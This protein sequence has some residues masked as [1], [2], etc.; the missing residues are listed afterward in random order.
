MCS[1]RAGRGA[2]VGR[3]CV[4]SVLG[5]GRRK[6]LE[7]RRSPY[8]PEGFFCKRCSDVAAAKFVF[9]RKCRLFQEGLMRPGVQCPKCLTA[10]VEAEE[11]PEKVAD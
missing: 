10:W 6:A 7:T 5:P 8:R 4:A 3:R 2:V 9:V 11:Q 1:W